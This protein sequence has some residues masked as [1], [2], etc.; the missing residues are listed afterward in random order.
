MSKNVQR[1]QRQTQPVE[2]YL[3]RVTVGTT[4]QADDSSCAHVE[5]ETMSPLVAIVVVAVVA[6][7]TNATTRVR[8]FQGQATIMCARSTQIS[9]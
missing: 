2:T 1:K 6:T 8:L 5:S 4:K 7:R 3:C 9:T